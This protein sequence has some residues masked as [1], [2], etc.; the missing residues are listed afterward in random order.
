M[1]YNCGCDIPD[2]DMGHP[3]NI[4]NQT[5]DK[6]AGEMGLE[7][8]SFRTKLTH[9]L[10][11]QI[12]DASMELDPAVDEMFLRSSNAW[13]QTVEEAKKNTLILLKK[14]HKH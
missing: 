12:E 6:I 14:L 11:A 7:P 3:D 4:I 8:G 10:E 1:C 13:G 2:D 9:E 5:L